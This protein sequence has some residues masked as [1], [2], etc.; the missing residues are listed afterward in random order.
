MKFL[1]MADDKFFHTLQK[2]IQYL[3]KNYDNPHIYLYDWGIDNQ[4]IKKIL[5]YQS[6]IKIID[7]KN[8]IKNISTTQSMLE[9]LP[10]SNNIYLKSIKVNKLIR[11][12]I[13]LILKFKYPPK[14]YDKLIKHR[15]NFFRFE[16]IG[17]EKIECFIDF[18]KRIGNEKALFL[19]ADAILIKNINHVFKSS[20]DLAF[21]LRRKNEIDFTYGRCDVLNA[22]VIFFGKNSNK[23][24]I[25]LDEWKKTALNTNENIRDQTGLTRLL[26]KSFSKKEFIYD[27]EKKIN[28]QN[29]F[30][31]VKI[32]PCEMYNFN[33]IEELIENN[34]ILNEIHVLHFKGS[35]HNLH[36]FNNLC[37]ELKLE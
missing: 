28:I 35:R 3:I 22:G 36:T 7:W 14:I 8:R 1:F 11:H 25:F 2:S 20:F 24:N 12:I 9:N 34:S 10:N 26:Q 23:R 31:K 13:N 19:D 21:T 17:L 18:S 5:S 16:S 32:L 30:V 37:R 6:D 15:Y 4:N 33:W 29:K 27:C